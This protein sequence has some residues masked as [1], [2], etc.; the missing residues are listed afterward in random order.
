MWTRLSSTSFCSERGGDEYAEEDGSCQAHVDETTWPVAPLTCVSD[1]EEKRLVFSAVSEYKATVSTTTSH[2]AEQRG[3]FCRRKITNS[4]TISQA[5][6]LFKHEEKDESKK[7]FN[8]YQATCSSKETTED[9]SFILFTGADAV[10]VVSQD[11][12][13]SIPALPCLSILAQ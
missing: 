8:K 7:Y 10:I 3:G 4:E 13:L 1:F 9:Q 5:Q 11:N 6:C 12:G 2:T